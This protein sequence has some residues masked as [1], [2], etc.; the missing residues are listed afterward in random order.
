MTDL[1]SNSVHTGLSG[2]MLLENPLLNKGTAFTF[3]ERSEL[4]L[5]G[6][7]PPRVETLEEQCRRAY[8]SF[9]I[10]PTPILKHI[11]LR[12]LQDTNETLFYALVQRHLQEM[13]PIIYTPVVGQAC[14]RYSDLYR[15]P[16]GLYISYPERAQIDAML[17]NFKRNI[18]VIVVTDGERILGLGDQGIGGMGICIG[19]L[20]LY[21]AVGGITPNLTLPITLDCGTNNKKLLEDPNYL[22]WRHERIGEDDYF[23]FVEMFIQ[24]LKRRWPSALLQFE[25]FAINHATPLLEKYRDELCTFNDDIQGTAGVTAATL[26]AAARAAGKSVEDLSVAFLGGGSAGCGIAEQIIRLMVGRGLSEEEARKRIY[27]VDRDGLVHDQMEGLR[28]FQQ[29]LAHRF[30]DIE[31]WSAEGGISLADVVRIAKP[32]AIIGVSG[33]P[34]LFTREVIENMAVNHEQPIIFPL[35]NPISQVE[36]LP[37]DII[38]WTNG[39]AL[40]ATG[41]PF[42]PVRFNDRVYPIA[43]CNNIY[44]FPGLGLGVLAS[45]A[46]RITDKMLDVAVETL[47][48]ASPALVNR[49][50]P[51][52]PLL[53][54]IQHVTND[55]ALAVA[56][57]AQK[58]GQAPVTELTDLEQKIR[59]KRWSPEYRRI[60]MSF[61]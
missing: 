37:E 18:E 55:I 21:S 61:C 31:N 15:R 52:L 7:L 43:Q 26:M 44:I 9:A 13:L 35:S 59:A 27:M 54:R 16:R 6:L 29:K 53:D 23:E 4:D 20:S 8:K 22:G 25:D 58:E 12:S 2:R 56:L 32:D 45:G 51:L 14:Q 57:Q 48:L 5:H 40:I 38:K 11:Y 10:K 49:E 50:A 24:A 3:E 30:V 36:A 34:G 41:S 42:E 46:G 28:P 19:K 1:D 39:T 47:A 60:R 17:A 33:Q